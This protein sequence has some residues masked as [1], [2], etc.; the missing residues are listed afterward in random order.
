MLLEEDTV[1]PWC[2]EYIKDLKSRMSHG[3]RT[4]EESEC[5]RSSVRHEDISWKEMKKNSECLSG[6]QGIKEVKIN[7]GIIKQR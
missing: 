4:S 3:S 6:E 7:G 1:F 2:A 5:D